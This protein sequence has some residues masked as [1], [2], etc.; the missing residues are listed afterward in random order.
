MT[1]SV[2]NQS[3]QQ[4]L[5]GSKQTPGFAGT[6]FHL[7]MP[8]HEEQIGHQAEAYRT[9]DPAWIL[10]HLVLSNPQ[11]TFQFLKQDFDHP[12]SLVDQQDVTRRQ[13]FG[14]IGH[15]DTCGFEADVTPQ[16]CKNHRDVTQMFEG[17]PF[18]ANVEDP[19]FTRVRESR[20]PGF[21]ELR[22]VQFPQMGFD[23][24][25][26]RHIPRFRAGKDIEPAQML[27]QLERLNGGKGRVGQHD[28]GL[29]P[30]RPGNVRQ[31]L[32]N[33]DIVFDIQRVRFSPHQPKGDRNAPDT[34]IE[35]KDQ[36]MQAVDPRPVRLLFAPLRERVEVAAFVDLDEVNAQKADTIQG[37]RDKGQK[38]TDKPVPEFGG[39]PVLSREQASQ[40]E[41]GHGNPAGKLLETAPARVNHLDHEQP[42]EDEMVIV[43]KARTQGFKPCT[44]TMGYADERKHGKFWVSLLVVL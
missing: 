18:F 15:K 13:G 8:T 33:Q 22:L 3:P 17:M 43:A 25:T 44:N 28:L 39:M 27:Q 16:F 35:A 30:V 31:D 23:V 42:A 12:S 26:V 2:L 32:A 29:N 11:A 5:P 6:S 7:Q 40:L 10:R 19:P 21:L 24:R 37:S 36:Q 20:N 4:M 41:I 38:P 34:P 14:K 1:Q 9:L